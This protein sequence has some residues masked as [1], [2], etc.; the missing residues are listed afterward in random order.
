MNL[1]KSKSNGEEILDCDVVLGND[2][3]N[4]IKDMRP[5]KIRKKLIQNSQSVLQNMQNELKHKSLTLKKNSENTEDISGRF[6]K[7][8]SSVN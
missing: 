4:P 7:L 2:K 3:E 8:K 6:E 5:I 1:D